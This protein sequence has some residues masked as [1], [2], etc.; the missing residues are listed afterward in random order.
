MG[1]VHSPAGGDGAGAMERRKAEDKHSE[2]TIALV[3]HKARFPMQPNYRTKPRPASPA[4]VTALQQTMSLYRLGRV[5]H[6]SGGV[7]LGLTDSVSGD[8][9]AQWPGA[10]LYNFSNSRRFATEHAL[11]P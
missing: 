6:A 7:W 4:Q 2:N 3:V 5:A 11:L 8:A 1:E 10:E 9:Q